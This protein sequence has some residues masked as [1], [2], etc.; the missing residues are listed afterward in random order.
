MYV[1]MEILIRFR[2]SETTQKREEFGPVT[3]AVCIKV[4]ILQWR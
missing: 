2:I 3:V 4:K 1:L